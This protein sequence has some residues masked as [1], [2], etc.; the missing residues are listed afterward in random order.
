MFYTQCLF[1]IALCICVIGCLTWLGPI[2][3]MA[4]EIRFLTCFGLTI[5]PVRHALL[6]WQHCSDCFCLLCCVICCSGGIKP[7]RGGFNK[8]GGFLPQKGWF[9]LPKGV[10]LSPSNV[11]IKP[12]RV[13]LRVV[14]SPIWG[15][16]YARDHH[17][18]S[19]LRWLLAKLALTSVLHGHR[20]R[21]LVDV[22]RFTI[23][24]SPRLGSLLYI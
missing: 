24:R 5:H 12:P 17:K 19:H 11:G 10:V 6:L 22:Q 3:Q 14:F 4:S 9:Y 8:G 2:L 7:P 16:F 13:V 18:L 20:Q 1:R 21:F 23:L 15:W